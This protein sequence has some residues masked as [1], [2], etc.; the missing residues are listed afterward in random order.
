MGRYLDL[1]RD[2]AFTGDLQPRARDISDR[3]DK[4]G[5]S[6][7]LWSLSSLLSRP[8]AAPDQDSAWWRKQYAERAAHRESGQHSRREA[9]L[10]AWRELESRWHMQHGE[11]VP[12]EIC[13]G[14]RRPI[15][16]AE[17]L[18]LI[19]GARVHGS[20]SDCLIRHGNRWRTAAT[21]ALVE[22]GLQPPAGAP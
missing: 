14:C 9:E 6:G 3:S 16:A 18:D 13:G 21:R 1:V 11:R 15:G 5:P 20:G 19:D 22:F 4:R 2:S 8:D 7:G 10:L 17:A 12:R